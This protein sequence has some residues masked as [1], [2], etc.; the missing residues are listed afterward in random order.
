MVKLTIGDTTKMIGG[1]GR[2]SWSKRTLQYE[3]S[4]RLKGKPNH[5]RKEVFRKS[6][7]K[8]VVDDLVKYW[9]SDYPEEVSMVLEESLEDYLL[10]HVEEKY[11]VRILDSFNLPVGRNTSAS[12]M[13]RNVAFK[14]AN[15]NMSH[16][17][18]Q[19][20]AIKHMRAY[21]E[22]TEVKESTGYRRKH[23]HMSINL[24]KRPG[25]AYKS[26]KLNVNNI[27]DKVDERKAKEMFPSAKVFAQETSES[28]CQ[29]TE[30]CSVDAKKNME[31]EQTDA[32]RDLDKWWAERTRKDGPDVVAWVKNMVTYYRRWLVEWIRVNFKSSDEQ[33]AYFSWTDPRTYF[34]RAIRGVRDLFVEVI[35]WMISSARVWF[36]VSRVL[37]GIKR[38]MCESLSTYLKIPQ[39]KSVSRGTKRAREM[40]TY[41]KANAVDAVDA[42]RIMLV[43]RVPKSV[44]TGLT[45]ISLFNT[46]PA[47][48]TIQA[49][50]IAL[51]TSVFEEA[52][53]VLM[54]TEYYQKG[55]TNFLEFFMG[56][57]LTE[58]VAYNRRY[59]LDKME[60]KPSDNSYLGSM[61][62]AVT[63]SLTTD[64]ESYYNMM[65][66]VESGVTEMPQSIKD[67]SAIQQKMWNV[68]V[69]DYKQGI[70]IRKKYA[71]AVDNSDPDAFW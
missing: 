10:E 42:L 9:I 4:R 63:G 3:L 11:L 52:S 1:R 31:K 60:P 2:S 21:E 67:D 65:E 17:E 15:K 37:L 12:N 41:I 30:T 45:V 36:M 20:D 8:E 50:V 29:G 33:K 35:V 46:F 6:T 57:C 44:E 55:I 27:M 62:S 56:P 34:M 28:F 24:E 66:I 61:L 18:V 43:N 64:D 39:F 47:L 23:R 13:A 5:L 40:W 71:E 49:T 48:N 16:Q 25:E 58:L 32:M 26:P 70:D 22:E 69:E 7:T 59:A 19:R 68:L 51:F 53:Q 38:R 54:A 14:Y